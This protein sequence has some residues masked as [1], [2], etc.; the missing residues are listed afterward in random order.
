[1]GESKRQWK[2]LKALEACCLHC[3]DSGEVHT[4]QPGES[5]LDGDEIRCVGCG[6]PGQACADLDGAWFN[7]HDEP[8]CKCSWCLAVRYTEAQHV[9]A[10]EAGIALAKQNVELIAVRDRLREGL[11]WIGQQFCQR[12]ME[13]DALARPCSNSGDC[14]TEWCL[15]CYAK[16]ILEAGTDG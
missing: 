6:C 2:P 10:A 16:K 11:K 12:T 4:D 13:S 7:W 5:F 8:D 3:G 1:M 15:P 9:E 14:I